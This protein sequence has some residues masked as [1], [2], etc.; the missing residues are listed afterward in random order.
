MSLGFRMSIRAELGEVAK[1]NAAMAEFV[2]AQGLQ[3]S[4]RRSLHVVLDELLANSAMHGLA[5][6][7]DAG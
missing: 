3:A 5:G 7:E 2:A 1:V 6:R 4:V